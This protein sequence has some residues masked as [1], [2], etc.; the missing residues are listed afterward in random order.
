MGDVE[1]STVVPDAV[2]FRDYALE[3]DGE[4]ET[5]ILDN[6]TVLPVI[7]IDLGSSCQDQRLARYWLFSAGRKNNA[8]RLR[9]RNRRLRNNLQVLGVKP[10]LLT[11]LGA[12]ASVAL[13]DL[14]RSLQ[15]KPGVEEFPA[16][17]A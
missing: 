17:G 10:E 16:L 13:N 7:L 15:L 5:S 6:V 14:A 4:V 9:T 8:K 12:I 1:Y 2:A 11:A 3:P